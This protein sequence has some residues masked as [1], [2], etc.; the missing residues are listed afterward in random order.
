MP[1]TL[2]SASPDA[3]TRPKTSRG[4]GKFCRYDR[5]ALPTCLSSHAML[6]AHPYSGYCDIQGRRRVIEDFHAIRLLPTQQFYG[7]FDGHTGNLASKYVA[8]FL[9]D[10]LDER[11]SSILM[12]KTLDVDWKE[13][14][15]SSVDEA[16][17]EIH[18]DFL[19]ATTLVPHAYMDQSGTT[20]TAAIV[21]SLAV[22]V[23][24]LGDS[25]AVL[26]TRDGNGNVKALQLTKDH[27]ASDPIERELVESRGGTV[28]QAN[29]VNRVEGLLVITRSIGGMFGFVSYVQTFEIVTI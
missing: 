21:N 22:V 7:I 3:V 15:I 25:R 27:V 12:S 19:K 13:R 26:S 14:V 9:Y 4:H 29:G 8:R 1:H 2:S 11:L 17:D 23:A 20:A 28:V 24:S 16:F 10:K 18:L 6:P 5:S